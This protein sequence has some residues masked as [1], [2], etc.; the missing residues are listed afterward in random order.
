MRRLGYRRSR[1]SPERRLEMFSV[2][3]IPGNPEMRQLL[4]AAT[5]TG[6]LWAQSITITSPAD[7]STLSAIAVPIT[8]ALS[9]LP[10]TA[11][12]EFYTDGVLF[13]PDGIVTSAPWSATWYPGMAGDS[14]G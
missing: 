3:A 9:A 7:G 11:S 2:K 4:L 13:E 12:V 1:H 8:V 14:Y 5:L 10:S 6:G